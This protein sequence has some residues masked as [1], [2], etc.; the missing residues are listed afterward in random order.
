MIEEQETTMLLQQVCPRK[1]CPRFGRSAG[2]SAGMPIAGVIRFFLGSIDW[3]VNPN[4]VFAMHSEII[5]R[6]KYAESA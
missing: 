4:Q 6:R 3:S 5:V 2:F 1:K